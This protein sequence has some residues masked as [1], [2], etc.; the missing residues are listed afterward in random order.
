[1]D[2]SFEQWLAEIAF[3]L[4]AE[5]DQIAELS[6]IEDLYSSRLSPLE[7]ADVIRMW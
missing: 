5:V 7:A 2:L 6:G 1:M 3:I 4:M